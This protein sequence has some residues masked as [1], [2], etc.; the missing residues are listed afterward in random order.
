MTLRGSESWMG[1]VMGG[2]DTQ[3]NELSLEIVR[4]WEGMTGE[5]CC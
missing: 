1:P 4:P 2:F 5:K 3:T